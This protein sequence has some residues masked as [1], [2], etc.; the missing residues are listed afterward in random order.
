MDHQLQ[1]YRH[2]FRHLKKKTHIKNRLTLRKIFVKFTTGKFRTSAQSPWF[3]K[4]TSYSVWGSL[5][6]GKSF[7]FRFGSKRKKSTIP[8]RKYPDRT[9]S[10]RGK[11]SAA[12]FKNIMD[13]PVSFVWGTHMHACARLVASQRELSLCD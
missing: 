3:E 8:E 5:E 2:L 9:K 11:R 4:K 1:H 7:F 12:S 10:F 13:L 6:V